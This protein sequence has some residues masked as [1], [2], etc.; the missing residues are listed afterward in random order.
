MRATCQCACLRT[1]PVRVSV[2]PLIWYVGIVIGLFSVRNAFRR[3]AI[4]LLAILGVGIGCALMSALLGISGEAQARL[5]NTLTQVAGNMTV[6][7]RNSGG[8]ALIPS[9][10]LLPAAYI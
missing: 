8:G 5:D 3:K 10:G 1:L 9:F 4:A 6:T 7:E 2:A